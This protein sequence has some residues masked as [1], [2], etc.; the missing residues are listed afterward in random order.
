[1]SSGPRR[2][3]LE[4]AVV[5]LILLQDA[6]LLRIALRSAT[7]PQL[8]GTHGGVGMLGCVF[9]VLV[10]GV[11]A[12]AGVWLAPVYLLQQLRPQRWRWLASIELLGVGAGVL[13]LAWMSIAVF[14]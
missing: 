10:P 12:L 8:Q 2:L 9:L 3:T 7:N 4:A 11:A 5:G 1:M 14:L 6:V 13:C